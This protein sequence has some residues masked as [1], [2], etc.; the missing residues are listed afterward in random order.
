MRNNL[1]K[2]NSLEIA[3]KHGVT[4][5]SDD[6]EHDTIFTLVSWQSLIGS[7]TSKPGRYVYDVNSI[8]MSVEERKTS[9]SSTGVEL[10]S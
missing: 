2:N 7:R 6:V 10:G 9:E 3:Y 5:G 4:L 1:L 8:V